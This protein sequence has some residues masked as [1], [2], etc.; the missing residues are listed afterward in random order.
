MGGSHRAFSR[1]L[2]HE[3]IRQMSEPFI[4]SSIDCSVWSFYCPDTGVAYGVGTEEEDAIHQLA[5]EKH[6]IGVGYE[7]GTLG[8]KGGWTMVFVEGRS[9]T[10]HRGER[11]PAKAPV[12]ASMPGLA[13]NKP[14]ELRP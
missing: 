8:G 2:N 1:K 9:Q 11:L 6:A 10:F 13:C 12:N 14:E 7:R 3:V 4:A 5:K